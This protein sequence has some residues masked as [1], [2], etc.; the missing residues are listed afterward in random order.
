SLSLFLPVSL[1]AGGLPGSRA[2]KPKAAL[3]QKF[4]RKAK[5]SRKN[6]NSPLPTVNREGVVAKVVGS[7]D[8][9]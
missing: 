8:G 2:L 9:S 7:N 5:I 1:L 6:N 3:K 4:V